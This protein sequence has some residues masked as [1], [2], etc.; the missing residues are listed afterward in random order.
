VADRPSSRVV[1]L[2]AL[3]GFDMFWILSGEVFFISLF[4][5]FDLPFFDALSRQLEHS[6]WS[7]F[8]FYDL[9]FPLFI[10]I[11][12]ASLP[13]SLTK[14]LD[15]GESRMELYKHIVKR[16]VLLYVFGLLYNGLLNFDPQHLRYTG[17]LHRIGISYFFASLILMNVR[18]LKRQVMVTAGILLGYWVL[19]LLIPVPGFGRYVITPEGNLVGW[20]D[21]L[22]LPGSFCCRPYAPFGDNEGILSYLPA[23]ASCMLGVFAGSWLKSS[24]TPA[25]KC[26]GLM[27]A[28]AALLGI[29]LVWNFVF[30]INK[31]IWTSSYVLFA[32]GWSVLL[33][34]LFYWLIDVKGYQKWA[35]PFVVIG[36]NPITIYLVAE[37]FDF[38]VIVNIYSHA[39]MNNLG[40]WKDVYFNLNMILVKWLFVYFLYRQKIFLKV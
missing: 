9:I 28:G 30:P 31:L 39:F 24:E 38:G 14:R 13:F 1:S 17:V 6:T 7:G 36:M 23:V 26:K 19:L 22:L 2:D 12:G 29:A 35:F 16:T 32:G 18:S 10:F 8:T 21:R 27:A 20:I 3:R 11:T 5:L 25:R 4:R 34:C 33:L 15:R 40:S 37:L